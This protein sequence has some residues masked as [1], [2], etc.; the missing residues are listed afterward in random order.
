MKRKKRL[1]RIFSRQ[2]ALAMSKDTYSYPVSELNRAEQVLLNQTRIIPKI[3][4]A[5][6]SIRS[7]IRMGYVLPP[8]KTENAI[9]ARKRYRKKRRADNVRMFRELRAK[10]ICAI[11]GLKANGNP[12]ALVFYATSKK[13][14]GRKRQPL[15]YY[16]TRFA[17]KRVLLELPFYELRVPGTRRKV[18]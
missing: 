2:D 17:W 9:R 7:A 13:E 6:S 11:T 18:E 12:N 10:G 1:P 8:H 5:V 14:D 4:I 15:S 16:A 3:Q